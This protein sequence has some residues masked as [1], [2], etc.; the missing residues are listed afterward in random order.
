MKVELPNSGM[1]DIGE[2]KSLISSKEAEDMEAWG[3]KGNG[4]LDALQII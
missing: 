1:I 2:K 3:L 4:G